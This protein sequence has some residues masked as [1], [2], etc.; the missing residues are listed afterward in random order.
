[1]QLRRLRSLTPLIGVAL[2][3]FAVWL[4]HRE[5]RNYHYAD[6]VRELRGIPRSR[7]LF[8]VAMTLVSYAVLTLYDALGVRYVRRKLSY[9]RIAIAS[10]IGYGVSMTLGF[11]LLTGAP[12][13]YRLY[14]RWGLAPG[15][16]ARIVAFYSTTYWLGLLAVG[17]AAFLFDPP[18]VPAG[19]PITEAWMR[20][21]G[22]LLLGV[23]LAYFIMSALQTRVTIRGFRVELPSLK[24]ALAQVAS[25]SLDWV[26][27]AAVMYALLP[28]SAPSFASFFAVYVAGQ[29]AGHASHVPG[30]VG[31]LE[32]VVLLMLTPQIP[33]PQVLGALLAWRAVYYLLPLGMAVVTL[34]VHE[35]RTLGG[36]VRGVP[37]PQAGLYAA[38]EPQVLAV[39][40]FVCGAVLLFSAATPLV[41]ARLAAVR[42]WVPLPVIEISHLVGAVCGAGLL[43]VAR[44]VQMRLARAWRVGVRLLVVGILAS[45]LKALDWEEALILAGALVGFLATRGRFYRTAALRDE[46]YTPGWVAAMGLV[47]VAM[48][49]VGF[50]AFK[51]VDYSPALWLRFAHGADAS[52]FLRGSV[53]AGA[54]LAVTGAAHLLS[55]RRAGLERPGADDLAAAREIAAR[56]PRADAQLA[57]L[58][59]KT[60]LW[61]PQ[62]AA[63]L[64]YAASGRSWV[65]MGDPVGAA[66]EGGEL[67]WRFRE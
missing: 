5:L 66:A 20:P 2:F 9:G 47:L 31:V 56:S 51:H 18:R 22:A 52:R 36:R 32:S 42:G 40:A 54:V 58:G 35:L 33:A 62:R 6:L 61:G 48:V 24:M 27:A 65:A 13:R 21:I 38:L 55:P 26:V 63:F 15:E 1:M 64:M 57:L 49:A 4:L 3:G 23:L 67:A 29:A 41:P 19:F 10:L 8:A 30:G 37:E 39:A 46:P 7:L 34:A 43:L 50:F 60:L 28:P 53:A 12:L 16:I 45:L 11:P 44:G 25:S 17:G 59:D 14:S